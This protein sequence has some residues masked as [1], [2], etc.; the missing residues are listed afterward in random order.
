MVDRVKPHTSH[1]YLYGY[2]VEF[3]DEKKNQVTDKRL[4][5]VDES[6]DTFRWVQQVQ[7]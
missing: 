3:V 7:Q 5:T 6:M 1:T 4:C 2:I